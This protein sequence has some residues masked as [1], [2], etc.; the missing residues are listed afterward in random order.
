MTSATTPSSGAPHVLLT[1]ATG[2]IGRRFLQSLSAED[3]SQVTALTRAVSAPDLRCALPVR[4]LTADLESLDLDALP[5][6]CDVVLHL[7]APVP[8]SAPQEVHT[9]HTLQGT[10]RLLDWAV[11]AGARHVIFLSTLNVY[12]P[13]VGVSAVLDESSPLVTEGGVNATDYGLSKRAAER[14]LLEEVASGF[15]AI[16]VTILRAAMVY[17]PGMSDRSPLAYIARAIS[18]GEQVTLA[19]PDGHFL[20]PI[21]VDDV[22]DALRR[23]LRAP[24][25]GVFNLGGPEHLTEGDIARALAAHLFEPL[26]FIDSPQ[27]ALALAVSSDRLND[28][29]PDRLQTPLRA[30]LAAT[31]HL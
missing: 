11:G 15:P 25:E 4:W 24:L 27:P 14:F 5:A 28:A 20:T 13:E 16:T 30:G 22:C 17:G 2:F 7:S 23:C 18:S 3:A 1:G 12:T 31:F 8:R 19:S 26:A 10:R 21:F 29:Y 9:R 6:R